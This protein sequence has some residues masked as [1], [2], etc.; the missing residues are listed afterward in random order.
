MSLRPPVIGASLKLE[1]SLEIVRLLH[2][3]SC[4]DEFSD[5]DSA[6]LLGMVREARAFLETPNTPEAPNVP[7]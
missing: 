6:T 4:T 3:W 2:R 7:T 5:T 1:V